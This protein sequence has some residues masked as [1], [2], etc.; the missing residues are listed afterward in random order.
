MG[1][2]KRPYTLPPEGTDRRNATVWWQGYQA[3]TEA[4]EWLAP[5]LMRATAA[6]WLTAHSAGGQAVLFNAERILRL[7]PPGARVGAFLNSPLFFLRSDP[8]LGTRMRRLYDVWGVGMGHPNAC[9]RARASAPWECLFPEVALQHWPPLVP[10]FVAQDLRD[11]AKQRKVE[12]PA[13]L[14]AVRAELLAIIG[15]SN[16]SA[17]LCT[18]G[19]RC[20]HTM[21][22][23]P[24]APVANG[25]NGAWAVQ[26]WLR[27]GGAPRVRYVDACPYPCPATDACVRKAL[28]DRPLEGTSLSPHR[29]SHGEG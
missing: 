8:G 19:P 16:A 14:G 25:T 28:S 24:H 4:L 9:L 18:C 10:L 23:D 6:V 15:T 27:A 17:F 5:K 13:R 7:V 20:R 11:P 3:L 26:V 22:L 1:N 21:L 29:A 2:R 12:E